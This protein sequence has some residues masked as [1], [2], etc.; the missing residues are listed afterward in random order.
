MGEALFRLECS[1]A[2]LN[3]RRASSFAIPSRARMVVP[4][5]KRLETHLARIQIIKN[6][7]AMQLVVF[8]PDSGHGR[9]MNFEL[10]STDVYEP[11]HKHGKFGVR[12]VDAKFAMPKGANQADW[13][14]V[15]LDMPEYAG[16]HEDV[17]VGFDTEKDRDGFGGELPAPMKVSRLAAFRK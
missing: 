8:L 3:R 11:F 12:F 15:C 9:C 2:D 14:Y 10:R 7:R 17:V 6:E 5:H 16:E 13:D 1:Q 4:V